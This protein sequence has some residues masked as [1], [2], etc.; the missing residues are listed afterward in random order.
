MTKIKEGK[1]HLPFSNDLRSFF[2]QLMKRFF[3]L[4]VS[5]RSRIS[6]KGC[7]RPSVRLSI[8]PSVGHTLV[9]FLRN[10]P[11]S[12]KIASEI[13]R[14][15]DKYAGSSPENAFV[16]HTLFDLFSEIVNVFSSFFLYIRA[17]I[18]QPVTH[19]LYRKKGP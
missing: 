18:S 3:F 16:V 4:L 1:I 17:I 8:G 2:F 12:N 19:S 13:R 6:T 5:P 10:G 15:K 14:F 9:E 7:V 11:N